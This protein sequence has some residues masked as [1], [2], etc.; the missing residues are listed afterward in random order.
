LVDGYELLD[1]FKESGD[2]DR[3]GKRDETER[4]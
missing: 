4:K 2:R 3:Q 1:D